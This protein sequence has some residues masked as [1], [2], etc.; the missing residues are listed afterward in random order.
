MKCFYFIF[1]FKKDQL[2]H[3]T[4]FDGIVTKITCIWYT[5]ISPS[6]FFNQAMDLLSPPVPQN[7]DSRCKA[8]IRRGTA[9]CELEMYVEGQYNIVHFDGQSYRYL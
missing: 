7:A 5:L 3:K 1:S 9:F 4:D 2:H 8:L 6:I